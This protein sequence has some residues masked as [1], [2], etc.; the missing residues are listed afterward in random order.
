MVKQQPLTLC[1]EIL[2]A[3]IHICAFFDSRDE[4]YSVIL[5]YLQEGLNRKEKVINIL[6]RSSHHEHCE[7]LLNAGISVEEKSASNQL[8]ILASEDTYLKGGSFETERMLLLLEDALIE[9]SS[10]GYGSVRACGEMVWAL[11]NVPGTDE[12]IEYEARLN[13]LTPKYSCSLVCMYDINRFSGR[14]LTDVLATHSHVIM[15]G[16]IY[17]NPYYIEPL[18]FLPTIQ[19]R[20]QSSLIPEK[21]I[22]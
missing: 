10:E 18:K 5:P 13:L 8:N 6:E 7:R 1:G 11:K 9:A 2:Y 4:Q 16:R 21:S 12:L 3:P 15:N 17:K 19:R 20:R 14:V 22:Y